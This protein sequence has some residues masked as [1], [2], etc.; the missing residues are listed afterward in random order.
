VMTLNAA[1]DLN[2][3]GGNVFTVGPTYLGVDNLSEQ[4][5]PIV[6]DVTMAPAKH[7]YVKIA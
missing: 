7:T 1:G 2:C 6:P 5:R 4:V 3:K